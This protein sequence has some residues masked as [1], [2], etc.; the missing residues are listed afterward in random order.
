MDRQTAI[1]A[2]ETLASP[3]RLDVFQLLVR[4]EPSGL[5]AGQIST[6][7]GLP[8]TNLS[9]HLK[10]LCHA[11][12]LSCVQEGRYLRYR[13]RTS[14]VTE[15]ASFLTRECCTTTTCCSPGAPET[16]VPSA[17]PIQQTAC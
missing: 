16:A 17:G 4:N 3:V 15:L 5:V 11:G 13:A 8:P 10:A 6:E 14:V 2:F 12:L 9:F 1:T 7:L